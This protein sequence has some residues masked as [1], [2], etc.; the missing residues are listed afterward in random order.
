MFFSFARFK[1]DPFA[2]FIVSLDVFL[3]VYKM[4]MIICPKINQMKSV[5]GFVNV[6]QFIQIFAG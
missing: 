4:L 2:D 3:I 1:N 5:E 6:Q